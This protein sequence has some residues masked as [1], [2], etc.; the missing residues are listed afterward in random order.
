MPKYFLSFPNSE[1][2]GKSKPQ[3]NI[4]NKIL[5][6]LHMLQELKFEFDNE[7]TLQDHPIFEINNDK[8]HLSHLTD[9]QC[10]FFIKLIDICIWIIDI[11][12]KWFWG[13]STTIN[14]NEQE[15]QLK[16]MTISL[17]N[18]QEKI[19]KENK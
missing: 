16:Q 2:I 3:D 15:E 10:S 5:D 12:F 8:N 1:K 9:Q 14:I 13:F 18:V 4:S 17:T 7:K 19:I 11:I 6:L